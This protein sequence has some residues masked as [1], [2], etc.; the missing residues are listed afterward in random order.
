[1]LYG[2]DYI[3]HSIWIFFL[4][5]ELKKRKLNFK[6]DHILIYVDDFYIFT[7][8]E[9]NINQTKM[10]I[11]QDFLKRNEMEI[12]I[13]K[14]R[15]GKVDSIINLLYNFLVIQNYEHDE[16]LEKEY[17]AWND[18]E[19]SSKMTISC[20]FIEIQNSFL[21]KYNESPFDSNILEELKSEISK[22]CSAFN[23]ELNNYLVFK[24]FKR[25]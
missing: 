25:K 15:I 14:T 1:M 5:N 3:T 16:F 6:N 13:H 11:I 19:F 7:K 4:H 12:N 10:N 8:D 2:F 18:M 23:I 17:Q 22:L 20:Y 9:N 21:K 24:I